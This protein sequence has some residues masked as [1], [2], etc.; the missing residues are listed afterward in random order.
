VALFI[1]SVNFVVHFFPIWL[2]E[3]IYLREA[4]G[5]LLTVS[6]KLDDSFIQVRP[7]KVELESG[8]VL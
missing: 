3:P 6:F 5:V 4:A 7:E 2:Q 8:K 1:F